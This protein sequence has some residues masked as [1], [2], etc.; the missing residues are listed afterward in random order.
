MHVDS[1]INLARIACTIARCE[2][3]LYTRSVTTDDLSA[4]LS[5]C[6]TT[7]SLA[8]NGRTDRHAV[9]GDSC[10]PEEPCIRSVSYTHLT[11][12]TILRV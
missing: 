1:L 10:V 7:V 5:V 12:P 9:W 2:L 11:L 6:V 3:L 4:S 8:N